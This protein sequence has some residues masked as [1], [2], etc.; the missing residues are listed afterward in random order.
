[1]KKII[2][3]RPRYSVNY[4]LKASFRFLQLFNDIINMIDSCKAHLPCKMLRTSNALARSDTSDVID[5]EPHMI[6]TCKTSLCL[7]RWLSVLTL[8]V[9]LFRFTLQ[10]NRQYDYI[11]NMITTTQLYCIYYFYQIFIIKCKLMHRLRIFKCF[12]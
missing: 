3:T 7:L 10:Q 6:R 1:M 8:D 9:P 5:S 11:L 2:A 4:I 12:C